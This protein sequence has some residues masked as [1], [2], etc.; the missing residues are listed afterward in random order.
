MASS[1]TV[2]SMSNLAELNIV[3]SKTPSMSLAVKDLPVK[4]TGGVAVVQSWRL[5]VF[6]RALMIGALKDSVPGM[7]ATMRVKREVDSIST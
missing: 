1:T 4:A 5:K 6:R 7:M 3:V 2:A